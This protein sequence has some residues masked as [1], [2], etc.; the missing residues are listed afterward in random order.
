MP[1]KQSLAVGFSLMFNIAMAVIFVTVY[2]ILMQISNVSPQ[3]YII[4]FAIV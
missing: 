4:V 3:T 2:P 1:I